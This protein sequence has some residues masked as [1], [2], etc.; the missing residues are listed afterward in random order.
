MADILLPGQAQQLRDVMAHHHLWM[1]SA[2]SNHSVAANFIMLNNIQVAIFAFAGGMLAGVLTLVVM[3]QN[4]I[5]IGAVAALV[6]Q[7]HLSEELWSFVFPHGVIELSVIFMAGGAGMMIGDAVLRPGLLRRRDAVMQA[8]HRALRLL[9][10]GAALLVVAGTI[11]GFFSPSN[12]PDP[13]KYAVGI[14]TG[15]LLYS[16]L[17]GSRPREP[18]APY[19][20]QDVAWRVPWGQPPAARSPTAKAPTDDSP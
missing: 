17:L 1:Q 18:R 7:Y 16:Y 2:T 5:N 9:L 12:A 13:L 11:E 15:I 8:A 20:F 19:T 6:A 3:V 4:G 10:G 14:S